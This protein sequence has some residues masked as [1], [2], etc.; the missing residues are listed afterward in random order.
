MA[1]WRN[2]MGGELNMRPLTRRPP[3]LQ[4]GLWG[5][6]MLGSILMG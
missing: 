5:R 4:K 3:N 2:S 1:Q 6:A